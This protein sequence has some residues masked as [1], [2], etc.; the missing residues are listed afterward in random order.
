MGQRWPEQDVAARAMLFV[1]P[2]S[3]ARALHVG[4]RIVSCERRSGANCG[5]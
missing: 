3:S 4:D 1:V 2:S 5:V